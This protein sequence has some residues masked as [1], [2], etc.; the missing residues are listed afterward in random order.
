MANVF[1]PAKALITA[2]VA[3]QN[4]MFDSDKEKQVV[5]SFADTA[6]HALAWVPGRRVKITGLRV[7]NGAVL[8]DTA[9]N[10]TLVDVDIY[11]NDATTPA[12]THDV[13]AKAAA[14]AIKANGWATITISST[15]ADSVV[16]AT[17]SVRALF[18]IT[19]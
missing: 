4:R 5:L 8:Q 7:A 2:V 19:G 14:T 13:G 11:D 6:D 10:T 1:S 12:K 18:D 16:E 9:T 15:A 17:E 3:P